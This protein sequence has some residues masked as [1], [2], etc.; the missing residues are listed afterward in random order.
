ML[1][2]LII[3]GYFAV[4]FVAAVVCVCWDSN[5]TDSD[6]GLPEAVIF[7]WP[8]FAVAGLVKGAGWVVLRLGEHCREARMRRKDRA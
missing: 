5:F 6:T 2:A 1:I 8:I 4:G 7:L 3:A